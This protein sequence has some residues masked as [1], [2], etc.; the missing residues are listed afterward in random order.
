MG[1]TVERCGCAVDLPLALPGE[2]QR[3]ERMQGH[4]LLARAG[5]RVL[6]PGGLDLT[7]RMLDAL[8]I[9]ERDS[10][11]EFAPGLGI[12]ARMVL[13]ES[14]MRYCAVERDPVAAKRL[15]AQL[16]RNWGQVVQARAEDSGL[17]GGSA[18]VVYGE[19]MLSM[20]TAD[21]KERIVSEAVRLLAPGGRYGIH[22]LC[23]R[24]DDI[25]EDERRE[26]ASAMSREIHV[27]VQPLCESEWATLLERHG[28][29]L[30]WTG[31]A[32]MDLLEPRRMLRDEGLL[33]CLRVAFNV[34]RDPNLR[35][36]MAAMRK[37]FSRYRD[38]LSAISLVSV[39]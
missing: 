38:Y 29:K 27:G 4:W 30:V 20:Q 15:Q 3:I 36:R 21:Q 6:R 25:S 8:A 11:V 37:I 22:E 39:R 26:I 18:T 33:G 19:A 17:P 12:T 16:P 2:G 31:E 24:P 28:L 35:Q 23:L 34:I 5:K 9:S 14:P 13:R 10:V 1:E 7:R 32:A